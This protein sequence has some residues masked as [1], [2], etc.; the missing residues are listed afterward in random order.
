LERKRR[1]G[2]WICIQTGATFVSRPVRPALEHEAAADGIG[3]YCMPNISNEQFKTFSEQRKA[4]SLDEIKE[5]LIE[6]EPEI[7]L[8]FSEHELKSFLAEQYDYAESVGLK[9]RNAV[10]LIATLRILE[11]INAEL[12][13]DLIGIFEV[14]EDKTRTETERLRL[15]ENW[16]VGLE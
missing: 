3:S 14:L 12:K 6:N 4:K 15:A 11:L 16:Q 2:V 8:Y 5:Y 10:R 13:H 7:G 1:A 9:S